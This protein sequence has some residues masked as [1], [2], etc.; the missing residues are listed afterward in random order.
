MSLLRAFLASEIPLSLQ[1]AV[2]SATAGLCTKLGSDLIR[3]VPVHNMHLTLKFLGDI[4]PA[5]L[6]LIKQMLTT[7]APQHRAFDVEVEGLGAY[8][9]SRRPRVLWVGLNAPAALIS[10]QHS[11]ETATARLGYAS[12]ERGFS[13]HLTIGR[14]RQNAS[15]ADLQKIRAALGETKVGSLGTVHVAAVHLFK[16]ELHPSGSIYT[17]L[18]SAPLGKT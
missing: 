2:E 3:W 4:S 16:S 8:P 10:L 1:D 14:V 9:S 17:K 12:E 7:E 11:I 6:D 18:F 13:P 15:A 5:N